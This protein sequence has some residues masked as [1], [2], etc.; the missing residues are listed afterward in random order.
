MSP[1]IS[2]SI[3]MMAISP[4]MVN[5]AAL[6]LFRASAPPW[7]SIA[8]LTTASAL[9]SAD[10]A[11]AAA[12]TTL[13]PRSHWRMEQPPNEY[14]DAGRTGITVVFAGAEARFGR[15]RVTPAA[16]C[17]RTPYGVHPP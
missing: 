8:F 5:R 13:T 12:R 11:P 4:F 7:A 17:T 3:P 15:G 14:W 2:T 1:L 16:P 6:Y 10:A 9:S